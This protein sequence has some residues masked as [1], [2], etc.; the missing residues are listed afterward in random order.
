MMAKHHTINIDNMSKVYADG[1]KG[2][3]GVKGISLT[4]DY[5][6]FIVLT[7]ESGAGKSTLL[8]VIGGIDRFEEGEV[9]FC[10]T[11]LSKYSERQLDDY[12]DKNVSFVFQNYSLIDSFTV[13][14]NV[15][16]SM[17]EELEKKQKELIAKETL[18]RM[19]I[20]SIARRKAGRLSG[21]QKQRVAIARALV[22]NRRIIIADEPI[23]HLD[24]ETSKE[25]LSALSE[26]SKEKLVIISTHEPKAFE[27]YA[28]RVIGL[29]EGTIIQD[30]KQSKETTAECEKKE[31]INE[32]ESGIIPKKNN[33]GK[34]IVNRFKAGAFLSGRMIA[35]R[36]RIIVSLC[37]LFFFCGLFLFLFTS[38][39]SMQIHKRMTE[40]G[41]LF[42]GDDTRV[43][44]TKRDGSPITG[45]ETK[46]LA[47]LINAK[48]YEHC[49]LLMDA[50]NLCLW[51]QY[52]ENPSKL[53]DNDL[54]EWTPPFHIVKSY[55]I[56]RPDIGRYPEKES[57]CLVYVPCALKDHYG[58]NEIKRRREKLYGID[59]KVVGIKYYTENDIQGE[60]LLD[61]EGYRTCAMMA[62]VGNR[63]YCEYS[64]SKDDDIV[65]IQKGI[66]V[67]YD[68]DLD[69]NG[70][71]LRSEGINEANLFDEGKT[72]ELHFI[73]NESEEE[74]KTKTVFEEAYSNSDL[75]WDDTDVV[76]TENNSAIVNPVFVLDILQGYM[77]EHYGQCSF[78]FANGSD[79]KEASNQLKS[80][81][82]L[83]ANGE[84]TYKMDVETAKMNLW[85]I[86]IATIGELVILTIIGL[87]LHVFISRIMQ[88][89]RYEVTV[90]RAVGVQREVVKGS[91]YYQ[92]ILAF[93]ASITLLGVVSMSMYRS[94][95][96]NKYLLWLRPY[97]YLLL[98]VGILIIVGGTVEHHRRKSLDVSIKRALQGES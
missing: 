65:F 33:R 9:L 60:I 10:G 28:T 13:W 49:D 64:V 29:S 16:L 77:N 85:V 47:D 4:M 59:Y 93:M 48:Y 37:I 24:E 31:L 30:T 66:R 44:V 46:E 88:S 58:T 71:I 91:I 84:D 41:K 81:G 55:D 23:A 20:L 54:N 72:L 83:V 21:G 43:I 51:Y 5:G 62:Y 78:V 22:S 80:K 2:A 68:Y 32:S 17:S 12:R 26:A 27:N 53:S 1:D 96:L 73:L 98:I 69:A 67:R 70:I 8:N 97:H 45:D 6:E 25:I 90:M 61:P 40:E 87:A 36:P 39:F 82:Y 63:L 14:D 79:T 95:F 75:I 19:G 34:N 92:T 56:G 76:F 57:E 11:P 50:G 7:G 86:V 42:R 52:M 89:L 3:V 15:L 35:S 38:A 74:D 18:Q 94:A